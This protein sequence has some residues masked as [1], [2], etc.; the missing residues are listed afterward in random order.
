[1]FTGV[2]VALAVLGAAS[3]LAADSDKRATRIS[4]SMSR[5]GPPTVGLYCMPANHAL[6]SLVLYLQP[7]LPKRCPR[8]RVVFQFPE[9]KT[10][11]SSFAGLEGRAPR[12]NLL[13]QFRGE[14]AL[15]TERRLANSIVRTG[16]SR[17]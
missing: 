17:R 3:L 11:P 10:Q 16:I 7:F 8:P 6:Y 9:G 1:M 4:T 2:R 12:F 13:Q 15:C 5:S 14:G